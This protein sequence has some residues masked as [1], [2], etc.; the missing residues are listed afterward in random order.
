MLFELLAPGIL[1]Y[2]LF[3]S[4]SKNTAEAVFALKS[5]PLRGLAPRESGM[6]FLMDN[7]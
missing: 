2:P 1:P 4:N 3:G 6:D 7:G 5:P